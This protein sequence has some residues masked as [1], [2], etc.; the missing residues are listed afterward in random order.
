MKK[1]CL[2]GYSGHGYVVAEIINLLQYELIGYADPEEKKYNPYHLN[3]IGNDDQINYAQFIKEK[4]SVALG[5]G[6]N[7]TREKFYKRFKSKNVV[8]ESLKHP[9]SVV[10]SLSFIGEGTVVMALAVINPMTNIGKAVICNTGCIVE[11]ECIIDD[12]VHI[13]PGA[14]LGGNVRVGNTSFIGA[15]AFIKQGL[16]IGE[17]VIIGAGSVVINDVPDNVIVYGN[18]AKIKIP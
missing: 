2:A 8:F 7:A 5:I 12:F 3:F 6:D 18:P 11:H 4:I 9:D 10:S 16:T 17:N 15:N 1:I 13:A 14:V